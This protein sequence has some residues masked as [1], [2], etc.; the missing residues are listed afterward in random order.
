MLLL[1]AALHAL[2]NLAV[3]NKLGAERQKIL[4]DSMAEIEKKV[5]DRVALNDAERKRQE[6]AGIKAIVLPPAEAKKWS[7][8]AKDAAWAAVA[9]TSPEHAAKLKELLTKK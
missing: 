9:K 1:H 4:Q 6:Q 2:V 5:V 3:W 8:T 7:D